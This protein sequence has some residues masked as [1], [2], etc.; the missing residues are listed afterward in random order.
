MFEIDGNQKSGSG[1]ILR[2][3]I[4]LSVITQQPLHIVNIRKQRPQP[5]LKRQ[6]LESVL[7]AAKLC[8][9][10]VEGALLGSEELWFTPKQIVGGPVE[11]V[12]ETAGSIP[13]LFMAVLPICV[14][15]KNPVTLHVAKGGTDTMYAPTINYL[16]FVLLP[17][18]FK[19]GVK[20]EIS[21]QKYG[22][23]PKGMG[24]ATLTVEPASMLHHVQLESF[25]NL[26]SVNGVSVCTFLADRQ[27]AKRQADAAMQTLNMHRIARQA[28]IRVLDDLSNSYQKGSSITMWAKTDTGVLLGADALGKLGKTSESVGKDAAERLINELESQSTVDTF[29]ADMLIPYIALAEGNSFFYTRH[30]SEHVEANIWLMET[31]LNSKFNIEKVNNLL[32]RIEKTC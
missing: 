17:T 21:V 25:G 23:Y 9:A 14:Y 1:T 29:L 32:Y 31:M 19:M 30:V 10:T 3:A 24:E 27:V 22:Y 16:K 6:H 2:L 20:A 15:A 12:I 26:E 28:Q 8:N 5:G 7:T 4:A 18:L 13:M 11:A